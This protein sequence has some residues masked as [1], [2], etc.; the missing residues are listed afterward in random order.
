MTGGTFVFVNGRFNSGLSKM[1]DLPT[2]VTVSRLSDAMS[3]NAEL[4]EKHL[5]RHTTFENDVFLALNTAL[6]QDGLFVHVTKGT[7]VEQPIQVVFVTT[8]ENAPTMAFGRNLIVADESSQVTMAEVHVGLGTTP[9]LASSVTE[10]IAG[11]NANVD[12]YR[13][14]REG[15]T[16]RQRIFH[17]IDP[18]PAGTR[19]QRTQFRRH[20]RRCPRTQRRNSLAWR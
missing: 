10:I 12:H 9:F 17:G 16:V 11:D 15:E 7:V 5:A 20:D 4:L 1:A 8:S 2:G 6:F 3:N 19:L 14:T 18:R 13:V